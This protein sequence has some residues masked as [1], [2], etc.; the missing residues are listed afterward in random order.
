MGKRK[1]PADGDVEVA[2]VFPGTEKQ[3]MRQV[4]LSKVTD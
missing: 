3:S 4:Q 2:G 1:T